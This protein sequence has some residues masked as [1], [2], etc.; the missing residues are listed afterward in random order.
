MLC[1]PVAILSSAQSTSTL[2]TVLQRLLETLAE[3]ASWNQ[4]DMQVTASIGVSLYPSRSGPMGAEQL[5]RHADA[6]YR[7]VD[8]LLALG[9]GRVLPGACRAHRVGLGAPTAEACAEEIERLVAAG[10]R[11][12]E[13][14]LEIGPGR[15]ILTRALSAQARQV[16]AVELD[17]SLGGVLEEALAG[18]TNV[19]VQKI[20]RAHV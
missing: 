12:G 19:T 1:Y 11:E 9:E 17:R 7:V 16:I 4:Q 13:R 20:G 3:P 14:V 6:A 5:L 15:G 18:C 2:S 8:V 10:V